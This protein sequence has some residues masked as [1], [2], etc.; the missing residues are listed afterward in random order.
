[1]ANTFAFGLLAASLVSSGCTID[2][3]GQGPGQRVVIRE[4]RQIP[5]AGKP[6]VAIQTFDGSVRL[7]SWDRDEI[8]LDIERRASTRADAE[9]IVV[10]VTETDSQI[11]IE[12]RWPERR[13]GLLLFGGSSSSVSMTVSLPR[14]LNVDARTGDGAIDASD[15]AGRI[16]LR[17]GDGS[18]RMQRIDGDITVSTGDGAVTARDLSGTVVVNTG[19]GSVNI[20]GRFNALRAHT[21]DG[22]IAIDA[23]AGSRVEREWTLT[24]GDG[25]LTV[26]VPPD[27][28]ADVDARTGDGAIDTSGVRL[29]RPGDDQRRRNRVRGRLGTGGERVTLRTGDGS[30]RI[31]AR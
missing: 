6:E 31:I 8:Q 10:E 2:V 9:A 4:Q 30:I 16:E 29:T 25:S 23:R 22:A 18:I 24:A 15:L 11:R 5:V 14:H 28:N 17:T 3:Q 12:P 1:V 13:H 20:N 21:G 7:R 27:F 26:R 19:D